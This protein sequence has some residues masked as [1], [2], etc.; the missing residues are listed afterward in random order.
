[1]K[2][3]INIAPVCDKCQSELTIERIVVN[4][5]VCGYEIHAECILHQ[6]KVYYLLTLSDFIDLE[7]LLGG[8]NGSN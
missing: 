7:I 6:H 1:M 5:A 8:S 3:H 4:R 2:T